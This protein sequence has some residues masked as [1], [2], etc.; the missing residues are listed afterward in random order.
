MSNLR[1]NLDDLLQ[2]RTVRVGADRVQSHMGPEGNGLPGPE[3]YLR[4]RQRSEK[5]RQRIYYSGRG[6][7]EWQSSAAAEGVES[8]AD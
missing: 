4:I 7:E 3:D 1:I 6:R 5:T 2:A 8:R